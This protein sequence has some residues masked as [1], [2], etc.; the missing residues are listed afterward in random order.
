MTGIKDTAVAALRRAP[1]PV[2]APLV[3]RRIRR[4]QADP[5]TV[6]VAH[7]QMEF[8]LGASRPD[9][10]LDAVAPRHLADMIWRRELRWRPRTVTRQDVTG[11]EN[12]TASREP[13]QGLLVAFLHH[14]HYEGIFG[15]MAAAGAERLFVAAGKG[16][17]Q[18]DTPP[19]LHAL[20]RT[21]ETGA[22]MMSTT[23]GYAGYRDVLVDGRV[24]AIAVDLPGSSNVRFLGRDLRAATG[25]ARLSKETGAAVVLATASQHDRAMQR[26]TLS[27]PISP[28][29]H[30]DTASLLQAIFDGLEASVLAWPEA[31]EWPRAHFVQLDAAGETVAYAPDPGEP[32][33]A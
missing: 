14:G 5:E 3:R 11:I 23:V 10:D 12:L 1:L 6:A 4:A 24:F 29:D 17:F 7:R 20:G 32:V 31:Y 21:V 2:V 27:E 26:L 18:P 15:A 19:H 25:V 9:A 8:V 33:F 22:T 28:D 16:M 13:G 30:P